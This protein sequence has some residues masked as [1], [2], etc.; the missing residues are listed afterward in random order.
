VSTP[1]PEAPAIPAD[2]LITGADL[3][4]MDP[5]RPLVRDGAIAIRAGRIGWVGPASEAR[6]RVAADRTLDAS[7]QIALPGLIDTHFHTG[8]QLLRGKIIELAKRR[9]LRLPIW[10]NYLIPFESALTEEDVYLSGQLAYANALRVGTTCFAEAGGPHP[11]Q[12]ARAALDTGIRGLV[13]LSTMDTG[14]GLPPSMRF[15]TRDAV[16]RNVALVE[17]W[18]TSATDGRVGAW[19]ALRQLLVCSRELWESLR[20]AADDLGARI[21]IHLAEGT[22]EVEYAAEQ[23]GLRPAEYLGAIGFLSPRVH[24]AHSILLSAGEIDLYAEHQVSAAHCP[25]GNFIIGAPKVPEMLRRGIRV[26]LGTD[27]AASG[28]I[29]LFEAMRVSWVALQSH[30]GTPWHVRNVVTLEELLRM[31]TLGGAEALGLGGEVGSLEPGKRAD[32]VIASPRHLDMQPVYDPVFT[33]ARG[34]SGRDVES[35]IVDGQLVVAGGVVTTLDEQE[36][37]ARLAERW[38]V[39]M[40]RFES[41]TGTI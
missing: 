7:G 17:A 3:V 27:G 1:Q 2:L 5:A 24:A 36:L 38:P 33:A 32:I 22:Y 16:D 19:L 20:D 18:G 8:Q 41:M 11:D 12:M 13:A 31:A 26:G 29:D 10:R 30:Y 40:E 6:Q 21:H 37:R 4:T 15:S 35:V 25:L 9:Q 34:I 14:D 39:I 23:W 28:S